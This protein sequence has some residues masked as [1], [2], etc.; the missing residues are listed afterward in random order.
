MIISPLKILNLL[1]LDLDR[2]TKALSAVPSDAVAFKSWQAAK[3]EELFKHH[4]THNP[5]YRSFVKECSFERWEDIPVLQKSDFQRPIT[6]LISEGFSNKPLYKANTSGSTGQPFTY[7][8]DKFCHAL[9]WALIQQRYRHY[10]ISMNSLQARFYG[11]PLK[12]RS[13][14]AERA[15]D[16]IMNRVRF[17]VFDLS[18]QALNQFINMFKHYP[19]EYVYGYTNAIRHFSSY[20]IK[21]G[22]ILRKICPTLKCVIAT[23]EMCSDYDKSV[24]ESGTGVPCIIEYG[25]SETGV[26]GFELQNVMI[27]SDELLY[28]ETETDG[29][30]LV[31]SLFNYAF[32]MIRY[33][34]GDKVELSRDDQT[35]KTIIHRIMGRSDDLI[36][37][38]D[39]K[40]AAGLTVYYITRRLLEQMQSL[41]EI[42][43]TQTGLS[44]FRILY[45]GEG[46]SRR[47]ELMIKNSFDLYLQPGLDL[48]ILKTDV[49]RRR[50]NGK[51]QMF[52]SELTS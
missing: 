4:L 42:Y 3:K 41:K 47:E 14:I 9:A 1:G 37:L 17:P 21:E 35:G 12:G 51:L 52:H 10:G 40:V 27:G 6:Q 24:I 32:P 45:V 39:G 8:K 48:Q 7:A 11:V 22:I 31:T 19:F 23:A 38:P 33:K 30:L 2:A 26:I 46:L 50:A 29:S 15:K 36:K 18:Q 43:V 28:L 44:S 5:F 34:I 49:I 13:A 16:R 20:L 25:A